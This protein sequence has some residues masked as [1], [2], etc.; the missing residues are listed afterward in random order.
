MKQISDLIKFKDKIKDKKI[1]VVNAADETIL[2][3]LE[4]ANELTGIKSILIGDEVKINEIIKKEN[5]KLEDVL[6]I[7][8]KDDT[9]SSE[10]AVSLIKDNKANLLMKGLVDTK[11]ILRAVVNKEKGI[12]KSKLLSHVT[13]M[14]FSHINKVFFLTDCAMNIEPTIEQKINIIDNALSL[15]KKLDIKNPK[16]AIISAVE[17]LNPNIKSSVDALELLSYYKGINNKDFLID[18]PFAVDNLFSKEAAKIKGINSEVAN[19]PDI[20]LFPNID[21]GN[22]FYKT[23][24]YLANAKTAGIIIGAKAPIVLTSRADS[25]ESKLYSIFLAGV[26]SDEI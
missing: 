26:Y 1:V 25:L 8:S 11:E 6:I 12:R 20:L 22:V 2:K 3:T 23:A 16:V 10:I 18:G 13:M 4:K 24:I 14:S 17:K 19:D 7:D 21:S 9:S 15:T 5:I